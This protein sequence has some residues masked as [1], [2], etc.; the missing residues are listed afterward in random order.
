[1]LR[2]H[3][4]DERGARAPGR[5][6]L[7]APSLA[8]SGRLLGAVAAGLALYATFPPIG[9]WWL[10]PVG[11][12]LLLG[13]VDGRRPRAALGYGA[14]LALAYQWPLLHWTGTYVGA[15]W[16]FLL[17]ALVVVVAVPVAAMAAVARLPGAPL[18]QACVWVAG[19]ALI[20][21]WPFG[22]FPWAK[23]AFGQPDGVFAPLASIGGAPLVSVATVL[24]GAGLWGLVRA[25]RHRARPRRGAVIAVVALVVGPVA[26]LAV[27]SLATTVRGGAAGPV[28]T[29]AAVQGNVPRAG[30]DFASQ[31]RAVLDNHVARTRELVAA[32]RAGT[33]PRPDLV[34]WPENS[35][36]ID[37]FR[38][39]D[40]GAEIQQVTD[41]IGSPLVVGAVLS[42]TRRTGVVVDGPRNAAVVWMPRTGPSA[43]YVKRHLLPFGEY[44]PIRPLARVFAASEVD[45]VTDFVPGSGSGVLP[46]GPVRLGVATCYEVVFDAS[47]R[48]A[49]LGGADLLAVPTNNATFGFTDMTYQQQGMSRIRAIEHDRAVVVAATSGQ[50]AVI[51]PDGTVVATTGA[52]FTPGVLVERVPLRTTTTTATR[53]GA[54]PEWVLVGL[55]LAAVAAAL[56]TGTARTRPRARGAEGNR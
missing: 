48:D 15:V 35:S 27:G 44:M 12:A 56:V 37:P 3:P 30:L 9:L 31:R 26:G 1:V 53:L 21:R 2:T 19:E 7:G 50:S 23:L 14:V 51:A 24:T 28:V 42:G 46:A 11:V 38:N 49:V 20:E 52:L 40:A 32:V 43:Q 29:V 25:A 8:T 22:G 45:R 36:D 41:E 55:G 18:W 13:V 5:A 33:T 39:A 47:V 6:G 34:V 54:G 16:L 17:A 4:R 10:G